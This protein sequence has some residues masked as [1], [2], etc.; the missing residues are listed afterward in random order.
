[1]LWV[2]LPTPSLWTEQW[3]L[4]HHWVGDLAADH[5]SGYWRHHRVQKRNHQSDNWWVERWRFLVEVTCSGTWEIPKNL[6]FWTVFH[7]FKDN[8]DDSGNAWWMAMIQGTWWCSWRW[9]KPS[10]SITIANWNSVQYQQ[11]N[12]KNGVLGEKVVSEAFIFVSYSTYELPPK[13]ILKVWKS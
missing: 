13:T 2:E 4:F 7:Q 11:W 12:G 6:T 10:R 8:W 1:M 9:V 3:C 5:H